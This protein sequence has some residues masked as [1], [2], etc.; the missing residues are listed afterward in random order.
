[1][2]QAQ[3]GRR[4]VL[5]VLVGIVLVSLPHA[6]HLP[7]WLSTSV[8]ALWLWRLAVALGWLPPPGKALLL[9]L[10][11]ACG[12]AILGA[13]HT[14][15]GREAGVAMLTLM[16][17][18]KLMEMRGRR[19]AVLTVFLGL[20][21]AL[22]HFLYGQGIALALYLFGVAGLFIAALAALTQ[23]RL[24]PRQALATASSLIVQA[25]PLMLLLFL[26]FPRLSGPLWGL[27]KD[28]HG[29]MTGLS[30][31]MTP[32]SISQLV[33][34]DAVA[35]RAEFTGPPP[36]PSQRYWRGPV[37]EV[38]DGRSWLPF[39]GSDGAASVE[40]RGTAL[41]YTLT[42]EPHGKPWVFALDLADSRSLPRHTRLAPNGQLL[43]QQAIDR[44]ARF[45]L[46]ALPGA[47]LDRAGE[48]DSLLRALTLPAHGNPRT[49]ELAKRLRGDNP[50]DRALVRAALDLFRREPFHYTLHPPLLE[51]DGVDGFLFE[52]R[53]G[54]CEHYAGAFTF[55]MRAA[56][57]PARV[58]TG[59]QG[60]EFNRLAGY[61]I[62][63]QSDAHA[64]SEVWLEGE[65]WVRVDPT[66][67]VAAE[68]I[69]QGL[70][71][72]L[73][74]GE[75]LPLLMRA[76][77]PWLKTLRLQWD[78]LNNRWNQWVIGFDQEQ[79]IALMARLGLGIV[80]W[81]ELAWMLVAALTLG[82]ALIIALAVRAR[83]RRDAVQAAWE[84]FCHTLARAGLARAPNE[85]PLDYAERVAAQRPD[86]ALPVRRIADHYARL[87]Y[88]P[89]ASDDAL[90]ALIAAVRAFRPKSPRAARPAR[91]QSP[92]AG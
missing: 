17:A 70:A 68:R 39:R 76:Q 49:R 69:E 66:A 12:S 32:G 28:A 58:V 52:T 53:R 85:G 90:A 51:A 24:S 43:A 54:F 73:P 22:T 46:I 80:S 48:P 67:A 3:L 61:L 81:R 11:T 65:G 15:F 72:A 30:E 25:L 86:L 71:A 60:G 88:G 19:D 6:A 37:L 16:L 84:R 35:F 45:A 56:G 91:S 4:E 92:A 26:L 59:Y 77:A 57:V 44:R 5:W 62:V 36:P 63:R 64:W 74:A 89:P 87:R 21:V 38:F 7:V 55:L 23:P 47:R 83:P 31:T 42:L 29:A 1:M 18:L 34:S 8:L 14:L 82:M 40:P 13:Y 33:Q 79:Q 27:P 9:A 78:A 75:P 10:V 2:R 20:F 41:A 50:D